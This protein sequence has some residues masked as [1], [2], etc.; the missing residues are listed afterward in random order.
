VTI[1]EF[2]E[3]YW[4]NGLVCDYRGVRREIVSV[5]FAERLIGL[6]SLSDDEVDMVR[7][8]NVNNVRE[9]A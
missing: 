7:C 5:D 3:R 8:E 9:S 6:K 4:K 1:D 2:D